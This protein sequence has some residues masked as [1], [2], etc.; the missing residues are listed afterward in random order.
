[1]NKGAHYNPSRWRADIEREKT[2]LHGVI[3]WKI[4]LPFHFRFKRPADQTAVWP[5]DG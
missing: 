2:H 1:M 5:F 4:V 3:K